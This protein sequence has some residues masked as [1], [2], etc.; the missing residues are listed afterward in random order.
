M[1][2]LGDGSTSGKTRKRVVE[3][4]ECTRAKVLAKAL[5]LV[6]P[7][8]TRAA[9]AWKQR[10]K[11]S[12]AWLL[13]CPGPE[14][15]LA[16]KEF[17][18]AAAANLCLP[19]LACVG[20]VG[21]IIK[22]RVKIDPHGDNLQATCLRGDHWRIRHNFLVQFIHRACLW[23]GVPAEMEVFNLFSGLVR[24]EGLSRMEKAQQRQSLVPDLRIA[25]QGWPTRR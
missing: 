11:V 7:T 15:R 22:G 13:A 12:S 20:R 10:D 19:S 21:E 16:N 2:G 24:Q 25:I 5:E 1:E 9:W 4:I 6:R 23:A 17:A 14:T 18:E 8:S 3:A